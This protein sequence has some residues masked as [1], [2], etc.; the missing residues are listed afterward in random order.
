MVMEPL[1]VGVSFSMFLALIDSQREK[2]QTVLLE[3]RRILIHLISESSRIVWTSGQKGGKLALNMRS[4][5]MFHL[6]DSRR[7][8]RDGDVLWTRRIDTTRWSIHIP[9]R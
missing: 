9:A 3:P 1:D 7:Q 5:T 2:Q 4:Y 6:K 8:G